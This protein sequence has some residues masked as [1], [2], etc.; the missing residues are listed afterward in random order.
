MSA[1][2]REYGRRFAIVCLVNILLLLSTASVGYA[3]NIN[4][5]KRIT[6]KMQNVSIVDVFK[7]IQAKTD[8]DFFYKN[9]QGK[10]DFKFIEIGIK[11]GLQSEIKRFLDVSDLLEGSKVIN[12]I[13]TKKK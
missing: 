2:W 12:G 10:L 13:K 4:Q 11:T 9:E 3:Q 8:F 1:K 7:E 6:L 5:E